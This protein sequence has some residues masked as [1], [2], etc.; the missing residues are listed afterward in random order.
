[1]SKTPLEPWQLNVSG[2]SSSA[3]RSASQ[4]AF[5]LIE[6]LVVIAIIAI[7]AAMLL[8]ALSKAKERS[9][10]INCAS[11]LRQLTLACQIYANDNSDR[12][13][14][15]RTTTGTPLYWTW[16]MGVPTANLI[17]DNGAHRKILYDPS[18]KEMENDILWGGP[19][20]FNNSGYRVIG[21]GV[22]FPGTAQV[23]P[24]NINVKITPQ[25]ITYGM[26]SFAAPSPSERVLVADATISTGRDEANRA[27]RPGQM[28]TGISGGWGEPHRTPHLNG[29]MP[30]GGNLGM[31]DGHVEW[32]R[33]ADMRVRNLAAPYFWW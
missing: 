32:R 23:H 7:L 16:D 29:Q 24:T 28:Y 10:R 6:L 12:L 21:Y 13:P 8:P 4:R 9:K 5:T 25:P 18:F 27:A 1:M 26:L 2:I 33:F 14:T 22:T 30:A 3:A 19:N 31:L 20:G 15:N 11:N 17:T